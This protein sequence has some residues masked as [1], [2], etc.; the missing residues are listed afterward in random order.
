[1]TKIPSYMLDELLIQALAKQKREDD[2]KPVPW[3]SGDFC[4]T[5]NGLRAI[6]YD[7]DVI[8]N[9][10]TVFTIDEEGEVEGPAFGYELYKEKP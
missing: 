2:A 6:V 10:T 1:M 8:E 5:D 4:W 7:H 9:I 3:K